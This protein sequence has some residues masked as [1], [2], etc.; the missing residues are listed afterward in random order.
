MS[1]AHVA[2]PAAMCILSAVNA[3]Y[4]KTDA[5]LAGNAECD[6]YLVQLT[7]GACVVP[8]TGTGNT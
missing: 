2:C 7:V 6:T 3:C 8:L 5:Y 4:C 1:L